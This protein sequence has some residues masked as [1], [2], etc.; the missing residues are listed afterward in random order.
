MLWILLGKVSAYTFVAA[1]YLAW[2]YFS[3][4][5]YL[6]TR[7]PSY[8]AV[9]SFQLFGALWIGGTPGAPLEISHTA[10]NLWRLLTMAS[11]IVVAYHVVTRRLKWR[12]REVFELAASPVNDVTNGFTERP[13]PITRLEISKSELNGFAD[14]IARNLIALPYATPDGIVLVPLTTS[15]SYLY[16]YGLVRS[17]EKRSWVSFD[18]EGNVAVNI[19]QSDYLTYKESLSFDQLCA[20][21]GNLFVEFFEM[22][23][24]GKGVRIIDRMN[25][26]REHPF[27]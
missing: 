17:Y 20:S 5:S 6:R 19:S 22:C 11:M 18:Y 27:T 13:R 7:N 24:H 12:A 1:V 8:L 23:R 10:S 2:V 16:L 25:D 9:V 26:L 14:F 15:Q 4:S 21:F 3:F